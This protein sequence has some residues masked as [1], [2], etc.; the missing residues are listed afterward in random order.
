M[1]ALARR[2]RIHSPEPRPPLNVYRER[3]EADALDYA[4]LCEQTAVWQARTQRRREAITAAGKF[5]WAMML[6]GWVVAMAYLTEL[7]E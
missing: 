1:V 6:V 7:G 5:V 3:E 2:P 4:E